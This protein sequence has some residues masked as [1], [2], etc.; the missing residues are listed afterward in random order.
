LDSIS[1]DLKEAKEQRF[2]AIEEVNKII[3]H[4]LSAYSKWLHEAPLR[5]MLLEYKTIINKIVAGYFDPNEDF[6]NIEKVTNQV[7]K[8]IMHRPNILMS[9]EKM[10]KLISEQVDNLKEVVI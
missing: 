10:D 9:S 3:S 8:K 1:E 6:D 5:A 4:E 2:S 7:M